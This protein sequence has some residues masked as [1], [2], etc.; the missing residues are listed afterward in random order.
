MLKIIC[1]SLVMLVALM[2]GFYIMKIE[3]IL[4]KIEHETMR[5]MKKKN[6]TKEGDAVCI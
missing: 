6:P 2:S 4:Y 3:W 1:I 5:Y